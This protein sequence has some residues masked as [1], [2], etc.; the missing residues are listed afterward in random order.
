MPQLDD[1]EVYFLVLKW[2]ANGP[3]SNAAQA[4]LQDVQ[5]HAL[6]PQ[7]YDVEGKATPAATAADAAAAS[8][9]A[10]SVAY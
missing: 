5:Q 1:S 4:L 6:L 9:T 2:L 10:Y 8:R 3:C 7:R